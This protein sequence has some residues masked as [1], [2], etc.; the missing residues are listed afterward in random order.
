MCLPHKFRCQCRVLADSNHYPCVAACYSC[1]LVFLKIGLLSCSFDFVPDGLGSGRNEY[2]HTVFMAAGTQAEKSG[3][4]YIM[5]MKLS[6]L[7]KLQQPKGAKADKMADDD[8][9]EE[10]ESSSDSDDEDSDHSGELPN[11]FLQ[12]GPFFMSPAVA[13]AVTHGCFTLP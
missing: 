7:Q 13:K 9:M 8:T 1:K 5:L 6:N 4:N 3:D 12:H 11:K 2:P 10:D